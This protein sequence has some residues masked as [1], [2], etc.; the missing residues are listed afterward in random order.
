MGMSSPEI[1][2]KWPHLK[3]SDIEAALAYYHHHREEIDAVIAEGEK[4]F[5]ELKAQQP[6]ILEKIRQRKANA[7]DDS[8][9]PR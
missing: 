5:E 7:P 6:S 4:L 1:V 2:S 3:V 8:I 9:P